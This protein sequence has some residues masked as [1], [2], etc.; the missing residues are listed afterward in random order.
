[1][2][3]CCFCKTSFEETDE[4]FGSQKCHAELYQ[5]RIECG[6]FSD[7]DDCRFGFIK[8]PKYIT[9]FDNL[10]NYNCMTHEEVINTFNLQPDYKFCNDCI[11]NLIQEEKIIYLNQPSKTNPC[12]LCGAKNP[13]YYFRERNPWLNEQTDFLF[14]QFP[15][16]WD[17]AL[18]KT[19]EHLYEIAIPFNNPVVNCIK[20]LDNCMS[21]C[22]TCYQSLNATG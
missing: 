9:V 2:I 7:F 3:T 17:E 15:L 1:M 22:E 21:V 5:G 4:F 11:R 14:H 20:Q 19:N 10:R 6:Y 8:K 13:E 12:D 18:M 16:F